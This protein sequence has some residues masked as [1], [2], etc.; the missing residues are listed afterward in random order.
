MTLGEV[1]VLYLS[2]PK[3]NEAKGIDGKSL[4]LIS[5]KNDPNFWGAKHFPPGIRIVSTLKGNDNL[6]EVKIST[7]R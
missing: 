5:S 3:K 2:K 6:V 7:W 4:Y 1:M